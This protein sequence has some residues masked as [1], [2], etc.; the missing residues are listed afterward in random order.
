MAN[1][2]VNSL[3]LPLTASLCI[4]CSDT[5]VNIADIQ[6]KEGD[7]IVTIDGQ[8]FTQ[9]LHDEQK[10]FLYPVIGPTGVNMT[11]EFPMKKDVPGESQ[12]HP[13]QS[14]VFFTHGS[15]NGHDFWN[16][17]TEEQQ[18][19]RIELIE[20]EEAKQDS[21]GQ[22]HITATHK[23]T[24]K[25]ETLMTDRTEIS[26]SAD[27]EKRIIDFKISLIASEAD[28]ELGDT[29]E[30]CMGVR[31]HHK[32][33]VKDQGAQVIN[34]AGD[35]GKSVWGKSAKW[36]TYSNEILGEN[37]AISMLDHPDNFRYPTTWHARDYGLVAANAFGLKHFTKD[38]NNS[39]DII[40]KKGEQ[41]SFSYRLIFQ[42]GD[43]QATDLDQ[44]HQ[45][46]TEQ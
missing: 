34:S 13:W 5:S 2:I 7:Y 3:L 16:E 17:R 41:L 37:L 19:A 18:D 42:K 45:E 24:H 39:G 28:V 4:S 36:I 21:K 8:L 29:K 10:P 31:M 22:A 11:R 38:E 12:D 9:Y 33:R 27:A 26:F 30:G 14:S 35:S 46:W 44:L 20:V 23:W 40:L 15:V 32:F 25:G 1:S 6:E 43:P